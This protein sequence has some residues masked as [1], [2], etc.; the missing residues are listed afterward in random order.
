MNQ[1]HAD[2]LLRSIKRALDEA[3]ATT[4]ER[5][6]LRTRVYELLATEPANQ[7]DCELQWFPNCGHEPLIPD[8][9]ELV[10]ARLADGLMIPA[11]YAR[12]WSLTSEILN[13]TGRTIKEYAIRRKPDVRPQ[14]TPFPT[15]EQLHEGKPQLS[16]DE[17]LQQ[18]QIEAERLKQ[19]GLLL[20]EVTPGARPEIRAGVEI[21]KGENRLPALRSTDVVK[22]DILPRE[23]IQFGWGFSLV[24]HEV[25]ERWTSTRYHG[26]AE[27]GSPINTKSG[28]VE[29]YSS[30]QLALRALRNWLEG[31]F[32]GQLEAVDKQ[33]E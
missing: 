26:D 29:L 25:G 21:A 3:V 12:N 13:N 1:K 23:S 8:G 5:D 9:W 19:P 24:T 17:T 2:G 15:Q 32:A 30:R 18:L 22:P 4:N 16:L 6:V 28:S 27:R 33:L 14:S 10:K 31:L 11:Y 7:P 20:V